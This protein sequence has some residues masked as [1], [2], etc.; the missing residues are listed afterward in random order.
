MTG[1]LTGAALSVVDAGFSFA[2]LV[3]AAIGIPNFAQQ[4]GSR[5]N[6]D[7]VRTVYR[8][9]VGVTPDAGTLAYFVGLLDSGAYTQV[10][11][12][13]LAATVDINAQSAEIV[14]VIQSGIDF[15]PV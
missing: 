3:S 10:S 8:N 5:S 4:A 9:V 13:V 7:F 2:D 11:L 1:E 14:G 15:T 6:A 12:G